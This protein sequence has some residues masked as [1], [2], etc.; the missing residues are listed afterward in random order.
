M[1]AEHCKFSFSLSNAVRLQA[2]LKSME[3]RTT[4]SM[5]ARSALLVC[6][7]VVACTPQALSLMASTV[8]GTDWSGTKSRRK[9]VWYR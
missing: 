5:M 4:D 6:L 7:L 1:V 3:W 8:T 2:C 9:V